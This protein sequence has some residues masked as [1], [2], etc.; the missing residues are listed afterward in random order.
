MHLSNGV[1]GSYRTEV[2]N[3][4]VFDSTT[5]LQAITDTWLRIYDRERPHDSPGR[6][7]PLTFSAE[8]IISGAV[9]ERPVHLTGKLTSFECRLTSW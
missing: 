7:P 8:A 4:R 6:K 9:S 2:L 1:I 5:E 3:A